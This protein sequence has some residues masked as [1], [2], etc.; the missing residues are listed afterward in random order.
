MTKRLHTVTGAIE[1]DALGLFPPHEQ[2][3]TELRGPNVPD[4]AQGGTS[5]V[6]QVATDH[7]A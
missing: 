2:L 6:V 4:Y 3:F 7:S 5:A 1:I